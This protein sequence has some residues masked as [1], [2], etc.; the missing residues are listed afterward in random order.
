MVLWTARGRARRLT[1]TAVFA[2]LL[3]ALAPHT[4]A[5]NE[6]LGRL[7]NVMPGAPVRSV[8]QG[9][10]NYLWVAT[11][12][13]LSRYDGRR[14]VLVGQ[15]EGLTG[16]VTDLS[17]DDQGNVWVL[18]DTGVLL[19]IT[20]NK[21][22]RILVEE[23]DAPHT[24]LTDKG[25]LWIGDDTGVVLVA[26]HKDGSHTE[27]RYR[28]TV[29]F[30]R[31]QALGTDSRGRVWA[32]G[33]QGLWRIEGQ[34][35]HQVWNEPGVLSMYKA[36]DGTLFIGTADRRLWKLVPGAERPT[37][38]ETY[39]ENDGIRFVARRR[40][41]GRWVAA[42]TGLYVWDKGTFD[43]FIN[44]R[45]LP[46]SGPTTAAED[47][48]GNLW[49]GTAPGG[50]LQ[51]PPPSPLTVIGAGE[52]FDLPFGT[53]P[54]AAGG[55]WVLTG[56]GKLRRLV[57]GNV[58]EQHEVPQD[59]NVWSWRSIVET[60]KGELW[61][62]SLGKRLLHFSD[63]RWERAERNAKV[64]ERGVRTLL[65]TREQRLYL[66]YDD[67]GFAFLDRGG[68]WQVHDSP[69]QGQIRAM[70]QLP[71][72]RVAM[73]TESDGV[74]A[75]DGQKSE[76]LIS[77]P[78]N[79]Q[80]TDLTVQG[81]R[82]WIGSTASGLFLWEKGQLRNLSKANGLASD[83]VGKVFS[84]GHGY[85]WIASRDGVFRLSEQVLHDTWS[86]K[87]ERAYT[88]AFGGED[89]M[90]SITCLWG[91]NATGMVDSKGQLWVLTTNGIVLF[92]DP[93]HAVETPSLEAIIEEVVINGE[94]VPV[95]SVAPLVFPR[96]RG[97]LFFR[98]T[99]PTFTFQ[100]RLRFRYRLR[101]FDDA[102]TT[103]GDRA[104]AGF[105][106]VPH[107]NYAFELAAWFDGQD[108]SAAKTVRT[109]NIELMPPFYSWWLFRL[110]MAMVV[111]GMI[112]GLWMMR[113]RQQR[114]QAKAITEERMRIARD[115]HD[116]LDQ[117]FVAVGLQ[118]QAAT[119]KLADPT[120]AEV[121]IERANDLI[122]RGLAEARGSIWALREEHPNQAPL[123][124]RLAIILG[125]MV[126]GTSVS[127][128]VK[129]QGAIPDLPS[130]TR[131][132]LVKIMREGATNAIRHGHAE[133]LLVQVEGTPTTLRVSL[134]DDGSGFDPKQTRPRT[135]GLQG[136]L[137]R[138]RALAGHIEWQSSMQGPQ[139]GT[140]VTVTLP[141]NNA[142]SPST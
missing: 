57:E 14:F 80:L 55:T 95:Q 89:G 109:A 129:S 133:K 70:V 101:G 46:G 61:I 118:L 22:R 138:T 112:G 17:L 76:R 31:V 137:E 24:L 126:R 3:C 122:D 79:T 32:G 140:T 100:H 107:G 111:A 62:G 69:C 59:M 16:A 96:E 113:V 34:N 127:L 27:S 82:L 28:S 94:N 105:T 48:E 83:H 7:R 15:A 51:L 20:A 136:M 110:A 41:G 135:H 56:A 52:Q 85:L 106:N 13:G 117:T 142:Q 78:P 108:P 29:T 87:R 18:S 97:N 90:P 128:K 103:V 45:N 23:Q 88:M 132:E 21:T 77:F 67:Q 81:N 131:D 4:Q 1:L 104:T 116:T 60:E 49:I 93:P 58:V 75:F 19:E 33:E 9:P 40:A 26:L 39:T 130:T 134:Q 84:D 98:Y 42:D 114:N 6:I 30:P 65:L 91:W 71:D 68:A 44:E 73:G 38:D 64:D 72:G 74:C 11:S 92:H 121:H 125:E 25:R 123:P 99:A 5:A 47:H 2:G 141:I 35:M 37:V 54:S 36:D 53:I 119:A 12:V 124:A 86:G 120:Q 10:Q 43:R 115:L 50:L 102:W 66:A 63:G 8:V 139:T